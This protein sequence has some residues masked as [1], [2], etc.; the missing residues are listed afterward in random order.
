MT[1][2]DMFFVVF[3]ILWSLFGGTYIKLKIKGVRSDVLWY[4][5]I[6]AL[7]P[8]FVCIMAIINLRKKDIS[9]TK[10][11]IKAPL[12]IVSTIVNYPILIGIIAEFEC[13]RKPSYEKTK[14]V[15][16]V[17]NQLNTFYNKDIKDSYRFA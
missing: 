2:I 5:P 16:R 15:K 1:S 8:F 11:I 6:F 12:I 3:V 4:A 17:N 10:K 13:L 9:Y 14:I 7:L